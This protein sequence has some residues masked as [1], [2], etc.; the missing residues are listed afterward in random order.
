MGWITVDQLPKLDQNESEC[1][2]VVEQDGIMFT[3]FLKYYPVSGHRKEEYYSWSE[4][5]TGCGCCGRGLNP[6]H[7]MPLPEKP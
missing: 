3:A 7:W 2:L 6:T 5:S 4:N 1:L